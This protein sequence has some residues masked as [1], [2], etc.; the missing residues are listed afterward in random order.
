[1]Q[2]TISRRSMIAGFATGVAA[3]VTPAVVSSSYDDHGSTDVP[4]LSVET[5]ELLIEYRKADSRL[6][7][8][9]SL[10]WH[11]RSVF[12]NESAAAHDAWLER[13]R[14]VNVLLDALTGKVRA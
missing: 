10:G 2:K 3:G 5:Y 14:A 7:H 4:A 13:Q 12:S 1:M 9:R 11:R 8:I 6:E